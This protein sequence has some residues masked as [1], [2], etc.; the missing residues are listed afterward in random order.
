MEIRDG[1]SDRERADERQRGEEI[2][3]CDI[4]KRYETR[5]GA[6]ER[7]QKIRDKRRCQREETKD[8]SQETVLERGDKRQ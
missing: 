5:D 4:D 1:D 8:K 7:T 3:Q 2:G 6:R